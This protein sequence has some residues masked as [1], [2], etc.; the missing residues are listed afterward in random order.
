MTLK[1]AVSR[2]QSPVPY[3]ANFIFY[4]CWLYMQVFV[5]TAKQP[6]IDGKKTDSAAA[7]ESVDVSASKPSVG[8]GSDIVMLQRSKFVWPGIDAVIEAY[9]S[10]VEGDDCC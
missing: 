5:L 1:L 9:A 4:I 7:E 2:S 3:G 8:H 6:C 10:H